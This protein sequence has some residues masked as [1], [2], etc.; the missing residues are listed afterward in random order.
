MLVCSESL[1][2]QLQF[3]HVVP[4]YKGGNRPSD[5]RCPASYRAQ[6]GLGINEPRCPPVGLLS[7]NSIWYE[8]GDGRL[9][10]C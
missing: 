5:A 8:V 9:P 7:A 3:K 6:A 2:G 1:L 4:N 10:E